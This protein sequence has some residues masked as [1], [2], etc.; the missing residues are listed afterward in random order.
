M[1]GISS[2][3]LKG[4]NYPENRRKYNGKELQ[5]KEFADG[6]GLEWH[7]YGAR[8][9]DQQIG[10]WHAIDAKAEKYQGISPYGYA[11]DNPILFVDPDGKDVGVS[12]NREKKRIT[13]SSSIYVFGANAKDKVAEYNK[14]VSEFQ[15]LNGKYKDEDGNEWS[16]DIQMKFVEGTADDKKRIEEAG[17]G[18]AAENML[19]LDPG[20]KGASNTAITGPDGKA[21]TNVRQDYEKKNGIFVVVNR[22]FLTSR[23]SV[24]QS[25]DRYYASGTTAL[26]ETLHQYGLSDWYRGKNG[27]KETP[28]AFKHD[29]M[30]DGV[31]PIGFSQ[32][33]YNNIGSKILELSKVK[34]SDNFIS[35]VVVDLDQYGKLKGQ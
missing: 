30:G 20:M 17:S 11:L 2:N 33:H 19:F 18:V 10:R 26:H 12:I 14:A 4:M 32:T 15:G 27:L 3:A 25:T 6:S 7:D 24:L 1:A 9:Y 29:I 34:K 13:L 31:G 5:S 28:E 21:E 16:I 22:E 35:N 8:M 23:K